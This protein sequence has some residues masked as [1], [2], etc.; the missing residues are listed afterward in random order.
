M[1]QNYLETIDENSSPVDFVAVDQTRAG[2]TQ[3]RT[4]LGSCN[5]TSDEMNHP[6]QKLSG[7]QK[8]KLFFLKMIFAKCEVLIL[9]EPTRNLSPL[10][11]QALIK[12]LQDY[13]GV[14]IGVSHDRVFLEEIFLEFYRLDDSLALIDRDDYLGPSKD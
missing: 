5:F 2:L 3:V 7:G 1:P 12:A 9:D 6:I 13:Q 8:A 14:I 4:F 11:T 10:S